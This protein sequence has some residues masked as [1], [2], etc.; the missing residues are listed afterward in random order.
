[1]R[2]SSLFKT[3]QRGCESGEASLPTGAVPLEARERSVARLRAVVLLS[4]N[5]IACAAGI[6]VAPPLRQSTLVGPYNW[7]WTESAVEQG[8]RASRNVGLRRSAFSRKSLSRVS[9][10]CVA[11]NLKSRSTADGHRVDADQ[12]YGREVA[13]RHL[14]ALCPTPSSRRG[15]GQ[16]KC[17]PRFDGRRCPPIP[18]PT[19]GQPGPNYPEPGTASG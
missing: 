18:P 14:G 15:P 7:S 1:M 8:E 4:T 3:A 17:I 10:N 6:R 5:F 2:G 13:R 19:L 16:P 11:R 9:N 12:A